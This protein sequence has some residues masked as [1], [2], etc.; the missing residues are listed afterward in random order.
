MIFAILLFN[1]THPGTILFGKDSEV[2][3]LR[4]TFGERGR[5]RSLFCWRRPKSCEDRWKGLKQ[6]CRYDAD[7]SC[8]ARINT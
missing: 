5:G 1:I 4:Q 2:P 7:E 8:G 6:N 3:S